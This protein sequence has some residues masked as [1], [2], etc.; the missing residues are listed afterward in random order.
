LGLSSFRFLLTRK[1]FVLALIAILSG[2]A[3]EG[4]GAVVGPFLIANG[5]DKQM[6]GIVLSGNLLAML[7]GALGGGKVSDVKGARFVFL[8]SGF[9]LAALVT[10][11]GGFHNADLGLPL[12]GTVCLTYFFIGSF[13][14]ASY[15]YYMGQSKGQMEATRFTFLMAMT[16]LCESA[17]AFSVGRV[18]TISPYSYSAGFLFAAALSLVGLAILARSQS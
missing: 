4:F 12:V 1:F 6:V 8:V 5:F 14:A 17:A 9:V 18:I 16:N 3:F 15:S 11:M 13:T 2:F 10:L 7:L